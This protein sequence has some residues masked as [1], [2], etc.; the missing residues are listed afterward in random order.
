[1]E[2]GIVD[3]LTELVT[4]PPEKPTPVPTLPPVDTPSPTGE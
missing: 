3:Q 4:K 1:M 2:S